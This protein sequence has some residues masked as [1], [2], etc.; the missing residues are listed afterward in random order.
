MVLNSLRGADTFNENAHTYA[1]SVLHTIRRNLV[2]LKPIRISSNTL[3]APLRDH[4]VLPPPFADEEIDAQLKLE[5]GF[6]C[7]QFNIHCRTSF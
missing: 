1:H 6:L 5:P 7:S 3:P 4:P 2:H